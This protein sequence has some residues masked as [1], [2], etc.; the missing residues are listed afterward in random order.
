MPASDLAVIGSAQYRT[1]SEAARHS[2]EATLQDNPTGLSRN[3]WF[4]DSV[5]EGAGFALV[6]GFSCQVVFFGLLPVLC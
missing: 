5:L 6:W 3:R 1:D 2:R 4:A